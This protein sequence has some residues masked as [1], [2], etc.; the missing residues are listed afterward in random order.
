MAR[1]TELFQQ[2]IG[3]EGLKSFRDEQAVFADQF[4][5]EVNLSAAV[6]RTLDAY[7]VPVYLGAVP[8]LGLL[9]A[10]AGCEMEGTGDLFI[11]QDVAH[12]VQ[13]VR[14]EANRKLTDIARAGV[15]CEDVV[16]LLLITAARGVHDLAV[17][18]L[19]A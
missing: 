7:H 18:K 3:I 19:E 9:V 11:E 14:I 8:I 4:P 10:L 2:A 5:V 13:D 15:A 12:R 17:L 16:Q 1:F 6:L